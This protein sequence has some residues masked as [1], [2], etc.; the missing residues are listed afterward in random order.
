MYLGKCPWL[1]GPML[2]SAMSLVDNTSEIR[3]SDDASTGGSV[4]TL[5][6][7]TVLRTLGS[8]LPSAG[9]LGY[10]ATFWSAWAVII[11]WYFLA[12]TLKM[13]FN[14]CNVLAVVSPN[15]LA[16]AGKFICNSCVRYFAACMISSNGFFNGFFMYLC[17]TNIVLQFLNAPVL[18]PQHVFPR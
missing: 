14:S 2:S 8:F 5:G 17:L 12:V 1:Y 15:Y 6:G 13:T 3:L 7:C 10:G 11:S 16:N 18:I 4:S 9:T